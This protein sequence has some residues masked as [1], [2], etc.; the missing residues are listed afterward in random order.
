MGGLPVVHD[1]VVDA[2]RPQ[3]VGTFGVTRGGDDGSATRWP[4]SEAPTGVDLGFP[5]NH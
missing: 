5:R 1:R 3:F 4:D 2:Q